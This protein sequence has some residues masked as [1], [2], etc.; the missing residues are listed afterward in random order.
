MAEWKKEFIECGPIYSYV[1][2]VLSLGDNRT[3][4]HIED[5]TQLHLENIKTRNYIHFNNGFFTD[6]EKF[7]RMNWAK[8]GIHYYLCYNSESFLETER[9]F[10]ISKSNKFLCIQFNLKT[11]QYVCTIY[12]CERNENNYNHYIKFSDKIE[13]TRTRD[14]TVFNREERIKYLVT[15][16]RFNAWK[17][18][19]RKYLSLYRERRRKMLLQYLPILDLC[20]II[21]NFVFLE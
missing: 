3:L 21:E 19:A 5:Y 7:I 12:S 1:Y 15:E 9:N 14:S 18:A 2:N 4:E 11:Q 16:L 17:K 10:F 6:I 20:K 8:N 13:I